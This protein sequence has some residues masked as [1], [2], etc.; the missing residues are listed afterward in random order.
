MY[1]RAGTVLLCLQREGRACRGRT[2]LG[3][4]PPNHPTHTRA[5][6]PKTL[7]K[8]DLSE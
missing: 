4:P 3:P 2:L 8:G 1:P 6:K 5:L 7:E